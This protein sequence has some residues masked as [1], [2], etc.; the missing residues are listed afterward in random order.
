MQQDLV[1]SKQLPLG[2][3]SEAINLHSVIMARE[4]VK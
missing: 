1:E 2:P 3:K 4:Q